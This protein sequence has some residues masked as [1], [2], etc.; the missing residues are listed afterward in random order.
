MGVDL[1]VWD[2]DRGAAICG[3]IAEFPVW[4]DSLRSSPGGRGVP[5]RAAGFHLFEVGVAFEFVGFLRVL[6]RG[7]HDNGRDLD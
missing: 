6:V 7:N 5:R 2:L 1:D 3:A 4:L